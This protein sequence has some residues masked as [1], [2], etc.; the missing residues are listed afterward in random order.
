MINREP[1][2]SVK[3]EKDKNIPYY[4][5]FINFLFFFFF[6]KGDYKIPLNLHLCMKYIQM[7]HDEENTKHLI[8]IIGF[9]P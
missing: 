6:F 2:T 1:N 5:Y 7:K 3:K 8:T 9:S 4:F